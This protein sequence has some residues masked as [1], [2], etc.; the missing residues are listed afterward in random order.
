MAAPLSSAQRPSV[1]DELELRIESLAFGGAGVARAEGGY[2]VFVDGPVIV[3]A[4]A[5][6]QKGKKR[7]A[8][9]VAIVKKNARWG[10]ERL[11]VAQQAVG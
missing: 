3:N 4:W 1:G 6:G 5:Y 7:E 9:L 2:V 11:N 8:Q 10:L